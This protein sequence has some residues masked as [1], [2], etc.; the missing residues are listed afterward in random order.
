MAYKTVLGLMALTIGIL[1]TLTYAES[2]TE[3]PLKQLKN[4]I[5]IQTIQCSDN[6]VLIQSDSDRPSCVTVD[7]SVIL[8]DEDSLLVNHLDEKA[9]FEDLTSQ[10]APPNAL[11]AVDAVSH[12]G[13]QTIPQS[14]AST[15]NAFA[16]DFYKQILDAESDQNIFFSPVGM[17]LAFS[18]LYEGAKGETAEQMER[19]FGFESDESLRHNVTSYALSSLNRDD[20]HATLTMV[21]ALWITDKYEIYESYLD[22]ARST[23]L[24]GA[25]TVDF[26]DENDSVKRINKWAA[27]KTNDKITKVID[28]DVVNKDTVMVINNA[29]YFKGTWLTKFIEEFTKESKFHTDAT[30]SVNTD[31]MNVEDAFNYTHSDGAQV[32]QMPY[33]GDRLSMLVVLPDDP[34]MREFEEYLS[35]Q[36]IQRWTDNLSHQEVIVSMPKFDMRTNY[37]L[38]DHLTA[39]GMPDA[40]DPDNADLLGIAYVKPLFVG[41][42]TQDAFIKVNE[43]GTEA[44]AI[45]AIPTITVGSP[46]SL[47]PRPMFIADHPFLFVISDDESGMILFMGRISN[48]A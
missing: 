27:E 11:V 42:A 40:F 25:Q 16:V 24:A 2:I 19:V 44:A 28:K 32:L 1:A 36:Q 7:T 45:T 20:F 30:H 34:D 9:N 3:N 39:M 8:A 18:L 17:H 38:N 22:I 4:D 5:L 43:G 29:I 48:P 26:T 10:T 13:T 33:L 46:F 15:N 12:N 47:S 14:L 41:Q 31:F 21:N 37:N 35:A 23:Y 6:K